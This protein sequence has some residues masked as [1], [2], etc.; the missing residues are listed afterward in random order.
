M[1]SAANYGIEIDDKVLGKGFTYLKKRQNNDGGFDYQLNPSLTNASI[2]EGTAGDVAT[3]GLMR[4]FDYAVMMKGYKFLLK[5]GAYIAA[6]QK[7]ILSWQDKQGAWPIKAWVK[8]SGGEGPAY[9]TA[10]ATLILGAGEG[11]LSIFNRK[12]PALP[13]AKGKQVTRLTGAD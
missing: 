11:R 7:D 10:F 6:A 9:A 1:V 2:R 12:P 13:K 3:L 4:K 5:T 8:T